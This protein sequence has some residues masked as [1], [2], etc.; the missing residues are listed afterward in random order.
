[1]KKDVKIYDNG[2]IYEISAEEF[3]MQKK[4]GEKFVKLEG[5]NFYVPVNNKIYQEYMRPIWRDSKR[6]ERSLECIHKKYCAF[7]NC[8]SCTKHEY[9][10]DSLEFV[11]ENGGI[12]L[13][14]SE[15]A[16]ET[17]CRKMFFRELNET[18]NDFDEVDMKI[19]EMILDG[20]SERAMAE[21]L[22][23]KSK[24]SV[25]KRKEKLLKKIEKNFFENR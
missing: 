22:G 15:S 11:M 5:T 3:N 18:L 9:F 19:F 25:R 10:F 17:F 20:K 16:E 13:P 1:M 23:F 21:Q 24:N 4:N 7:G 6:E 12:G 2:V 8:D 14:N